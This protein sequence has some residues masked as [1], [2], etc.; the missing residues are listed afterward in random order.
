MTVGLKYDGKDTFPQMK[1]GS[2]CYGLKFDGQF[3]ENFLQK[4][5]DASCFCPPPFVQF[6]DN[7]EKFG[8]CVYQIPQKVSYGVA[9]QT[10]AHYRTE[11]IEI[12]SEKKN[13]FLKEMAIKYGMESLW[14]GATG[15][16]GRYTW[17]SGEVV[18]GYQPWAENQ[19]NVADGNCAFEDVNT[20][21][22]SSAPCDDD[23]VTL[24]SF[25]CQKIACDTNHYCS[26]AFMQP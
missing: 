22:W 1:F 8:E 18:S 7:C 11:M 6:T 24:H 4:L 21:K 16:D 3:S 19:P 9:A 25:A 17:K 10:C 12:L 26:L 20:G 23:F 13:K 5:C 2:E 15:V 14:L